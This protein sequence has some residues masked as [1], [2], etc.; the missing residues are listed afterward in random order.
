MAELDNFSMLLHRLRRVHSLFARPHPL[1]KVADYLIQSREA[2]CSCTD[3]DVVSMES[4]HRKFLNYLVENR[5]F[6]LMNHYLDMC[7]YV[8]HSDGV[9]YGCYARYWFFNALI[10]ILFSLGLSDASISMLGLDRTSHPWVRVLL[11]YRHAALN[12][13]GELIM[14]CVAWNSALVMFVSCLSFPRS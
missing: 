11:N 10:V 2:D 6:S 3:S 12:P 14:M 7:G 8:D 13:L 5:F 1:A 4:F 9:T